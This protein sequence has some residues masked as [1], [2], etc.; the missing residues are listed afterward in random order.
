MKKFLLAGAALVGAFFMSAPADASWTAD[1]ITYRLE[2]ATTADPL[3]H[4]F[5]LLISGE[6]TA[7]DTEGGGRTGIN[8][9]AFTETH[10][11][12]TASGHMIAPPSG[13]SFVSGGL[14]SSGC[15][16]DPSA[17]FFCF[18]NTGIPPIPNAL[19]GGPLLFVFDVTLK[20]GKTWPANYDPSFKIDWVGPGQNN[21]DL[22]SHTLGIET[23][24]PDCV[25]TPVIANPEPMSMALLGSGLFG[26]GMMRRRRAG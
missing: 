22:V 17:N 19:L 25:I 7:L 21:Y 5:A 11:G 18:D 13:F 4:I 26:L 6:N 14:Q 15:Q 10:N 2:T 20:A 8:A 12:D 1:G 9:I 24:C 3:T 23:T 16:N